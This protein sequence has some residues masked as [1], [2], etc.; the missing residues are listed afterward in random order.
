M[1]SDYRSRRKSVR[2]EN[3]VTLTRA[4]IWPLLIGQRKLASETQYN[5]VMKV[6][7]RASGGIRIQ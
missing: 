6:M 2:P 5:D 3:S 4:A 1:S 7:E